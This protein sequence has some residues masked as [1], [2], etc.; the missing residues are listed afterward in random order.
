MIKHAIVYDDNKGILVVI[1]PVYAIGVA[2]FFAMRWRRWSSIIA[3]PQFSAKCTRDMIME[4]YM[5]EFL[6]LCSLRFFGSQ[7][8]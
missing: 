4:S 5:T 3:F 8:M 6:V 7:S 2:I 1:M